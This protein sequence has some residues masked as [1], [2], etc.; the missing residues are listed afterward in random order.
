MDVLATAPDV[1]KALPD[2]KDFLVHGVTE[3]FATGLAALKAAA[4]DP[5]RQGL[6]CKGAASSTR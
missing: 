3:V 6:T 4:I 2:A 1:I 5:H